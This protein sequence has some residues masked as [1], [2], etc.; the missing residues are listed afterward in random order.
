MHRQ[1]ILIPSCFD[2]TFASVVN[3]NSALLCLVVG[4]TADVHQGFDDI[5]ECVVV[6]VVDDKFATVILKHIQFALLLFFVLFVVFH[7]L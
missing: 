4:E 3:D 2:N 1:Q 7:V 5:V 6:V